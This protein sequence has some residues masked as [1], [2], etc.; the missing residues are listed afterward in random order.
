LD[1]TAYEDAISFVGYLEKYIDSGAGAS[2]VR[3]LLVGFA[4]LVPPRFID[5]L[6]EMRHQ[7]LAILAHYF[8]LVKAADDIW[9][10]RGA[11]E[12]EVYGIQSIIPPE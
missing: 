10:M 1:Q 11:S 5:L 4:A 8:S 7:A 6:E 12:R 9:W 3:R 2:E